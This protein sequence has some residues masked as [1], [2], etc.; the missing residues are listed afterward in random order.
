MKSERARLKSLVELFII[1]PRCVVLSCVVT[2][3]CLGLT[4]YFNLTMRWTCLEVVGHIST[5]G[6]TTSID[7][8]D[9][10]ASSQICEDT[11]EDLALW[12]II[13]IIVFVIEIAFFVL[14][15]L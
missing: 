5:R 14:N 6:E 3:V 2:S 1:V 4:S 11:I 13:W 9:I 10:D 15:F 8:I 7:I 12:R